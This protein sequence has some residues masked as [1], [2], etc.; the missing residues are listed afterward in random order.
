M[1]KR[2]VLDRVNFEEV[3]PIVYKRKNGCK[4][5]TW[6]VRTLLKPGKMEEVIKAE[7]NIL[8]V[9]ETKWAGCGDFRIIYS[10]KEEPGRN[11]VALFLRGEWKSSVLNTCPVSYTH[12]DVYKRQVLDGAVIVPL[13][14]C[15]LHFKKYYFCSH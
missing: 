3:N 7:L 12:L 6:N 9:C 8:G 10:G 13:P 2:Q 5:G 4:I 11:G 14:V 15:T 1:Y